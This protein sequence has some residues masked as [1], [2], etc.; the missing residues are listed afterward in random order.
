MTTNC[1]TGKLDIILDPK[2]DTKLGTIYTYIVPN[3][4]TVTI[5]YAVIQF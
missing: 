1:K 4:D 5:R 3:Y 2:L